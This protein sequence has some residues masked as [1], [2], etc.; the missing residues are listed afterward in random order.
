MASPAGPYT[1]TMRGLSDDA[2]VHRAMDVLRTAIPTAPEMP[3]EH[4]RVSRWL[5]DELAY[6]SYSFIQ[7]GANPSHL[8]AL[9]QSVGSA[10]H[11]AGCGG[12]G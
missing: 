7:V 10:L 8:T 4:S 1:A 3:V 6:G 11:F 9:Q 2:V 12:L 5:E